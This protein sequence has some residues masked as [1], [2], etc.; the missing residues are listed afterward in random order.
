MSYI[1]RP[2]FACALGG[3]LSTITALP[4]A[5]P[6]IHAAAGCGG[7]LAAAQQSGNGF[8]GAGYCG[9]LALPSS[10]VV[11]NEIV[12]GGEDR[13]Q[14]QIRNTFDLIEAELYVVASGCMTEIIGDD[15]KNV[16]GI[17][18]QQGK[19]I[20]SINAG[21]FIGNSY[22]GF[23]ITL[24]TLFR[25]WVKP[26]VGK[27]AKRI[28]LWG[29]VPGLDPFYR[30]DLL[31]LK[32]LLQ[33][34]GIEVNTF[35]SYDETLDNLADAAI[36]IGNVVVS[37]TYAGAAAAAFEEKFGTPYI[38]TDLPIGPTATAEFLRTVAGFAGI[39]NQQTERLIAI[40]TQYY[41]CFIERIADLYTDLDL[42]HYAVVVGNANYSFALTRFLADDLG[43]LP[44]LVVIT[45][46]L[47][48]EQ[49]TTLQAIFQR[50]TGT[51]PPRLVFETDTSEVGRHL[52]A[53]WPISSQERYFHGFNPAFVIGSSLERDL[54]GQIG[55]KTLSVSYPVSDRVILDRSY[56]GF[57]GGLHLVE[58]LLDVQVAGGGR[59]S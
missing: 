39:D 17:F 38:V 35:F 52:T 18:K 30:G 56:A 36:A 3:V 44:E 20:I 59:Y 34:L 48:E 45:D 54:A 27:D 47:P 26:P 1:E 9:G 53:A 41:Y 50:I 49:Q 13:L 11:E 57:R 46:P 32:R 29:V 31:E 21:G 15:I 23:E 10:N 37:R 58:D 40:E 55:A 42:Q 19:P 7:N 8:L 14:E 33:L 51:K 4:G 22:K 12:F 28:N 24:E 25:E 2:R 43:W 6:I 16:A 5:V